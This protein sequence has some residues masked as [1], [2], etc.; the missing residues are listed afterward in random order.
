QH[1]VGSQLPRHRHRFGGGARLADGR[2]VVLVLEQQRDPRPHEGVVVDDE[3]PVHRGTRSSIVVPFAGAERT[4]IVP[5]TRAARSCIETNPNP[6]SL[7]AGSKPAPSSTIL[8]TTSSARDSP[9]T[10]TDRAFACLAAL[11]RLS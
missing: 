3:H 8:T 6:P 10:A 9:R 1:D 7:S 4:C 2:H 5:L 11:V